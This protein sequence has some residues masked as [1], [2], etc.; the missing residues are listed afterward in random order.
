MAQPS[1]NNHNPRAQ[2]GRHASQPVGKGAPRHSQPVSSSRSPHHSQPVGNRQPALDGRQANSTPPLSAAEVNPYSRSAAGDDYAY[3]R[4][5]KKRRR[6][7]LGVLAVVLAVALGGIG[8]AFAYIGKIES[9]LNV[10]VTEE[11]QQALEKPA[12]Y[13]GGTFYMLL[14]GT[15]KS[16]ERDAANEYGD[17]YRS[18][19]MILTR[20]DPQNK[21]V[22]MVSLHRDTEIEIDGYGTQKLNASYAIDGPAG[23]IRAVSQMAGVP[24]SH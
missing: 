5:R 12:E 3:D 13:D 11:V 20:V 22:T 15:D 9:Q 8:M 14:L 1:G 6:I 17:S 24:I 21:K 19:S 10:G 16:K 2:R 4:R 23:A 7:A 18:D